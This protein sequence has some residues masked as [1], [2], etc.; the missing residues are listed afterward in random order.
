MTFP[1]QGQPRRPYLWMGGDPANPPAAPPGDPTTPPH[2][3]VLEVPGASPRA[4]AP[5]E[6]AAARDPYTLDCSVEDFMLRRLRS[7][8][9]DGELAEEQYVRVVVNNVLMWRGAH[10]HYAA[11]D[12]SIAALD[13]DDCGDAQVYNWYAVQVEGKAKEWEA[14]KPRVEIAGRTRDY[15]LEPVA[16]LSEAL[17]RFVRKGQ[18]DA[19]FR[20]REAKF[21]MLAKFYYRHSFLDTSE[22]DAATRVQVPATSTRLMTIGAALSCPTCE[23]MWAEPD[24]LEGAPQSLGGEAAGAE[25]QEPQYGPC[26]QCGD[27]SPQEEAPRYQFTRDVETGETSEHVVPR[28]KWVSPNPLHVKCDARADDFR[29]SWFVVYDT[30]E[31]RFDVEGEYE[32]VDLTG[33]PAAGGDL[34]VRQ[35]AAL[36]LERT[37]AG[38][39]LP[40]YEDVPAAECRED[41]LVRCRRFWMLPRAYAHYRVRADEE[42]CGMSFT[43]GRRLGDYFPDGWLAVVYG[44]RHAVRAA[45][46]SKNRRWSGAPFT[47]DPTTLRGKGTEDLNS[48]QLTID[49]MATL[50]VSHFDRKGAPKEIVNTRI[51]DMDEFDGD[52]G[53]SVP[54]KDT[55]PEDAKASDAVHPVEAGELGSDF[56]NFFSA[57]PNILREVGQTSNPIVGLEDPHNQTARGREIAAQQSSSMLIPSLALRAEVVEVETTLQN[58]EYCQAYW[59]DEDFAPFESEFGS[60]AIE[61]FRNGLDGRPFVVRRELRAEAVPG[62]WIPETRDAELANCEEFGTKYLAPASQNLLPLSFVKYAAKLYNVPPDAFE[63]EADEKLAQARLAKLRKWSEQMVQA[64][65]LEL[66]PAAYEQVIERILS[67]PDLQPRPRIENHQVEIEFL[68][69]QWKALYDDRQANPLLLDLIEGLIN[70]H[71]MAMQEA[72]MRQAL[73]QMAAESAAN[74]EQHG[75]EQSGKDADAKRQVAVE[76][77]KSKFA[78]KRSAGKK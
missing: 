50:A 13:E 33:V 34:L 73:P 72:Q 16:R 22:T 69:S 2:L 37:T 32:G 20:Q 44:D 39:T 11:A 57:L 9:K 4:P 23:H 30:L 12:G 67:E 7:A 40:L 25:P 14:S 31:R 3:G 52:T 77:A 71:D 35:R 38:V 56:L 17:D 68:S 65:A 21:G 66:S 78:P 42:F 75:R 47:L 19:T 74:D 59:S 26:P 45:N 70:S 5:A 28:L 29:S 55:A 53:K 18:I 64:G 6:D 58:L 46:E 24:D 36:A 63:P 27:A 62:S 15:R 49:D 8:E 10:T 51:V 60:E 41:E 54:M 61:V 43:A 76:K 48:P 1:T